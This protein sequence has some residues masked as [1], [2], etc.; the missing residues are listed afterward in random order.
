MVTFPGVSMGFD[1]GDRLQRGG[2]TMGKYWKTFRHSAY[3]W[4]VGSRKEFSGGRG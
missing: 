1:Y 3:I 2:Q 4:G